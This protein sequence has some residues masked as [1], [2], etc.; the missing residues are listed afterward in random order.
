MTSQCA[1]YSRSACGGCLPRAQTCLVII[2]VILAE[3][4]AAGVA[5]YLVLCGAV[6]EIGGGEKA[7]H[8]G[9]VKEIIVTHA[10][11]LA[12]IYTAVFLVLH[13]GEVPNA[14]VYLVAQ[15]EAVVDK[16]LAAAGKEKHL[17][18]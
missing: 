10:V 5:V 8:V 16:Q 6:A 15:S 13:N 2:R 9:V 7:R 17:A 11:H 4:K 14:F 12:S 3:D 1:R 18:R